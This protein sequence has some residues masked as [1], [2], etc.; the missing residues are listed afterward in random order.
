MPVRYWYNSDRGIDPIP[1]VAKMIKNIYRSW[2]QENRT[3]YKSA[4]YSDQGI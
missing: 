2:S 1:D 4:L 3:N